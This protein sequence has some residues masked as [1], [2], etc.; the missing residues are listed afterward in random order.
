MFKKKMLR[1]E[2]EKNTNNK[3]VVKVSNSLYCYC[4]CCFYFVVPMGIFHVGNSGHFLL[5][6]ASCGKVV[7]PNLT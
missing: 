1:K 6:K 7:L 2:C 4:C 3:T 5:R